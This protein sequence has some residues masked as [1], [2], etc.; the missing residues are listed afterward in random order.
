M[1]NETRLIGAVKSS[2]EGAQHL[3]SEGKQKDDRS[4][5]LRNCITNSKQHLG[6]R[7]GV[8]TSGLG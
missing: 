5:C 3:P 6:A 7:W 1:I 2:R 8:V 4:P